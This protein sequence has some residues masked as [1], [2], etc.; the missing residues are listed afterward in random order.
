MCRP[1]VD[2]EAS[3]ASTTGCGLDR[4]RRG[5]AMRGEAVYAFPAKLEEA[6]WEALHKMPLPEG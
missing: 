5:M 3:M 2:L 1:R 4:K 6:K